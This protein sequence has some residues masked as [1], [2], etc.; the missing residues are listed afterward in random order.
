M[1]W[2]ELGLRSWH[3]FSGAL[4]NEIY[5]SGLSSQRNSLSRID[6]R[7][8]WKNFSFHLGLGLTSFSSSGWIWLAFASWTFSGK[9]CHHRGI[10]QKIL[11]HFGCRWYQHSDPDRYIGHHCKRVSTWRGERTDLF[12]ASISSS[13]FPQSCHPSSIHAL[14]S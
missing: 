12:S 3:V 1:R 9:N 5:A 7:C 11:C 6:Y 2:V 14:I 4:S 13:S 8:P 10:H